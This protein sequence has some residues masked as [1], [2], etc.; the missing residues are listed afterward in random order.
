MAQF[1]T[2]L[3][4]LRNKLKIPAFSAAIV[5]DQQLVW[6]KGFGYADLENQIEAAPDTPYRLA[7]VTKPFAA[8]LIMQLVEELVNCT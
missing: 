2:E 8:I 4:D 5:K 6:A 3:D 1:E 7:S